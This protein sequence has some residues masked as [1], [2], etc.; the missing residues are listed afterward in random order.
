VLQEGTGKVFINFRDAKVPAPVT[1]YEKCTRWFH[2]CGAISLSAP[3]C[4]PV[5]PSC[6]WLAPNIMSIWVSVDELIR[7][8]VDKIMA[9]KQ[10]LPM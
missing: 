5:A 7:S 4:Q 6:N 3:R 9:Q 8:L 10:L 2:H 1:W